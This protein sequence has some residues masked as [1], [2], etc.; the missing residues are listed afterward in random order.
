MVEYVPGRAFQR[1]ASPSHLF[2]TWCYRTTEGMLGLVG[3]DVITHKI[4]KDEYRKLK[5]GVS[6]AHESA[7]AVIESVSLFV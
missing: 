1:T 6:E 5:P 3:R 4:A 7:V 2:E